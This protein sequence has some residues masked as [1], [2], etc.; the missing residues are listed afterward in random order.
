M[1]KTLRVKRALRRELP[2]ETL[3]KPACPSPRESGEVKSALVPQRASNLHAHNVTGLLL[4]Q[5][6]R[7]SL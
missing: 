2:R 3:G 5:G 4:C 6:G 7:E 1:V